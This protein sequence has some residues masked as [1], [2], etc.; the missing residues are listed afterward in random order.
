[1]S[2]WF[3]VVG[4]IRDVETIA[5]G[6]SIRELRRLRKHYGGRRWRKRKGVASIECPMVAWYE[7]KYTGTK[8]TA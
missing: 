1:V 6:G 8:L 7:P 5:T 2:Y 3:K 4:Q